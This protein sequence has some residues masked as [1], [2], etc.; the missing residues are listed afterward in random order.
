MHTT[1]NIFPVLPI[2]HL[3]KQDG[4]QTTP[5][6]M[7]TYTKP[8]VSKPRVLFCPCVVIKSTAHVETKALNIRHQSIKGF[9]GIFVGI[10]QHQKDYIIYVDST[11]KIVSSHDIVFDKTFSS[12]LSYISCPYSEALATKLAVLYIPYA[13]SSHE[14]TCNICTF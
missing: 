3:V 1:D 14:Q 13:T 8:S 4:E 7:E 10:P 12:E 6:K 5:H 2:K 11:Q 9:G